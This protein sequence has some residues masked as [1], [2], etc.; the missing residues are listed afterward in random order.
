VAVGGAIGG[1][2]G[3]LEVGVGCAGFRVGG[4]AFVAVGEVVEVEVVEVEVVEVEVVEAV[5]G[6]ELDVTVLEGAESVRTFG[7]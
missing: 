1:P 4:G 6:E 3:G 2:F 5:S 7:D